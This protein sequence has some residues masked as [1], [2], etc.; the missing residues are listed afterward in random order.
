MPRKASKRPRTMAEAVQ[1]GLS[2]VVQDPTPQPLEDT[3]PSHMTRPSQATQPSQAPHLPQST[4]PP[5]N[6]TVLEDVKA[7]LE[8]FNQK[9]LAEIPESLQTIEVRDKIFHKVLGKDGHGYCKTYGAGVP[10]NAVYGQ[11]SR[12]SHA[13]SSSTLNEIT[14]QVREATQEIEQRLSI[15]I[16]Q[17]LSSEIEQR[18]TGEIEQRLVGEMKR[19][20]NEKLMAHLECMGA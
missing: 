4:Q 6:E 12:L 13:S 3:H 11:S 19:M 8:E 10:R 1:I 2:E 17:W 16:E 18:L 7:V 14:R 9:V 5:S 20:V 15:E